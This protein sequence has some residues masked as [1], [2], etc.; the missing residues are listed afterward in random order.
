MTERIKKMLQYMQE[1]KL[2]AFL[3]SKAENIRYLSGFTGGE[4][5]RLLLSANQCYIFTDSRYFEQVGRE[6]PDWE[7]IESKT[8][9]NK[10]LPEISSGLR[11]IGVEGHVITYNSYC[12]LNKSLDNK[13]VSLTGVVEKLRL[14]KEHDELQMMREAARIGDE[15]FTDLGHKIAV[16][17]SE[18]ELASE[19]AYLLRQK[20]CEGEAF[21]TIALAGEN[22]ALPHGHPGKYKLQ[23]GDMLTMDFGGF[24][25]GYAADMTRTVAIA[26][27]DKDLQSRYQAVLESQQLGVS[28]VKAGV[29]CREIDMAVRNCLGKY[30][31]DKYFQH[32]TG[33]GLGLEIHEA[34]AVSSRSDMV[35]EENMVITVEPGIYIAGWGGI[36]IEDTVIVKN[37]GCE[38]ITHSN[39]SLLI[40]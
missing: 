26:N 40:I 19:I 16:G 3:V 37:G 9:G 22:A 34:P 30:G 35:L 2:D 36:R 10:E 8:L 23:P 39:K 27:A 5:A 29:T 12:E 20:G 25:R 33:H 15:V 4:D 1:K 13:L 17:V 6:C 21:A 11:R 18:K 24:Y 38:V 31:L 14:V 28:M 7:L 32:S